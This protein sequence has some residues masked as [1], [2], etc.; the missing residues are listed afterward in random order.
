M[1]E[2]LSLPESILDQ[3]RDQFGGD[4]RADGQGRVAVDLDEPGLELV[5]NHKIQPEKLES[6]GLIA[7]I[8]LIQNAQKGPF[9]IFLQTNQSKLKLTKMTKKSTIIANFSIIWEPETIKMR[10]NQSFLAQIPIFDCKL[11]FIIGSKSSKNPTL[12]SLAA[13]TNSS[14]CSS[15]ILFPLSNLPN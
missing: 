12:S 10:L 8:D 5:I 13:C 7:R 9:A 4:A 11:T 14:S 3:S 2:V 15:V 6:E 1:V